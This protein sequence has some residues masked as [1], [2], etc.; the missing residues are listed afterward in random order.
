M[1]VFSHM[2]F[3]YY[4]NPL[5]ACFGNCLYFCFSR[6]IKESL[7]LGMFCFL[8][9]FSYYHKLLSSCFGNNTTD[10]KNNFRSYF[11]SNVYKKLFPKEPTLLLDPIEILHFR[12]LCHRSME[13]SIVQKSRQCILYQCFNFNNFSK[14]GN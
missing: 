5:F 2:F 14:Y 6:N 9:L 8:I 7:N 10:V 3:P 1:F 4:G 13:I 11:H 12:S